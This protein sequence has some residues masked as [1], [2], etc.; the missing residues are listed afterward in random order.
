MGII[1]HYLEIRHYFWCGSR[2]FHAINDKE[3]LL[4]LFHQGFFDT[5]RSID[6][7]SAD[8][9]VGVPIQC[10][11]KEGTDV[12]LDQR[13]MICARDYMMY[14]L[15]AVLS[16]KQIVSP[17][18]PCR[19]RSFGAN[20]GHHYATPTPAIAWN[21]RSKFLLY[22]YLFANFLPLSLDN[23]KLTEE[24]TSCL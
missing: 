3:R 9:L 13:M 11:V 22:A 19:F 10:L 1:L 24:E 8:V 20:H 15:D 17:N 5:V 4:S 16:S 14:E 21:A 18:S 7:F 6:A 23:M 2:Q 12:V